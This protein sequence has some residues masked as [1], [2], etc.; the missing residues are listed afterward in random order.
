LTYDALELRF[1]EFPFERRHDCAVCG[2]RPTILEP[3][4]LDGECASATP[5]S[6]GRLSAP[7]L[8]GLLDRSSGNSELMLVD[9]REPREF[10]AGH[11]NGAINVPIADLARRLKEIPPGTNPVFIC[12]SGGRSLAACKVAVREGITEPSHLEGGLLA[13]ASEVDPTLVVAAVD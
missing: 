11:L 10:N 4:D 12:R 2:D 1:H 3:T 13:W 5:E 9:V 8:R 6:I 7:T